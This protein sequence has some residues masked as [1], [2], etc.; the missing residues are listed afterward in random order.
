M[1]AANPGRKPNSPW[2]QTAGMPDREIWIWRQV[3]AM[4]PT[5]QAPSES[6]TDGLTYPIIGAVGGLALFL[7][8]ILAAGRFG[9]VPFVAGLTAGMI[10]LRSANLG[11]EVL[12]RRRTIRRR[13]EKCHRPSDTDQWR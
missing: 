6:T 13:A 3:A 8:G 9:V 2:R 11:S 4:K 5:T 7:G 10:A 1:S 12:A